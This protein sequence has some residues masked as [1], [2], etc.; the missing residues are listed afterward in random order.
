MNRAKRKA[1]GHLVA[2][3]IL[4][5]TGW[6]TQSAWGAYDVF[7]KIEGI[8]GESVDHAHAGWVELHRVGSG[9]GRTA[10][11]AAPALESLHV[12]KPIDKSSP[13]LFRA[14]A[15]GEVIPRAI[16]EMVQ[17]QPERRRYYRI[18]LENVLIASVE[19][20]AVAGETPTEQ[21]SLN[22][23]RI[24]WT[25]TEIDETGLPLGDHRA[26]WD[27]V[28]NEGDLLEVPPFRVSGTQSEPGQLRL[29]WLADAGQTYRIRSS[30]DLGGGFSET[31]LITAE[32]DGPIEISLPTTSP[33]R[34]F[35]VEEAN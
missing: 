19:T 33:Y 8:P 1:P 32:W 13:L 35:L 30:T 22:F 12:T 31:S 16:L 10:S 15:S 34:F 26:Y 7:L 14:C 24:T 6:G 3:L 29:T 17:G 23:T 4:A 5:V 21:V 2:I 9:I 25:Y 28:R 20:T 27:L 11:Q 18:V